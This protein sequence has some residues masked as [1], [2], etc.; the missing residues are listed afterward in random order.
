MLWSILKVL[1]FLGIAAAVAFGAAWLLESPG[2]ITIAFAGRELALTPLGF[3]LALFVLLVLA[4]VILKLLGLLGAILRFLLGDET[5]VSRYFYRSRERRGLTALTDG[6][7]ALAEGDARTAMRHANKADKLLKRPEMTLMVSAPA[8]E[9]A[10]NQ[11]LADEQATEMLKHPKTRFAGIMRHLRYKLAAGETDKALALATKAFELRP[12]NPE[13]LRTLFALQTQKAEW[14]GARKTLTASTH[15]RLMPRDVAARRDAVLSLA[16]ARAAIDAGDMARGTEAAV[17]ANKLAPTLVPAAAL[18]ARVLA[19]KGSKRR[20][21]KILTAAWAAN[22]HPDIAAAFAALEPDETPD[23]RRR[24]FAIL[25]GAAPEHV[26]SKLLSAELALTAE[27]FPAARKALGDLAE[28]QPTTRSLTLMAA[29]ERGQGAPDQVV[30]GWLAKALNASRGPQWICG[31]CNY[32]HG[33]WTPVCDECGSFDTLDW[34]EAPTPDASGLDAT[35]AMLP[36]I[37]GEIEAP[38]PEPEPTPEPELQPTPDP[39]PEPEP[40]P[41]P[42]PAPPPKPEPEPEPEPAPEVRTPY[43][44]PRVPQRPDIVDADFIEGPTEG[45]RRR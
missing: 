2:E 11:A 26:E 16:D 3:V 12:A 21:V 24:R 25:A 23:A 37:V 10:G 43:V 4:L 9:L 42:Q 14:A 13:V 30:R 40:E 27:D 36:L 31:K 45:P 20:A 39:A 41:E 6:L 22:P 38:E 19:M 17:Q 8:A 5:A 35:T 29:I 44:E 15:A 7:V 1:F 33:T 32:I 34:K 18:A 28:T